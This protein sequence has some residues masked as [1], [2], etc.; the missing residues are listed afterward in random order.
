MTLSPLA[1]WN[2]FYIIVGSAAG[3]LTGLTFVVIA[4]SAGVNRAN[5]TGVHAFLTP[6]VVHFGAVLAVAAY[7]NVPRQ[8]VL[9]LSIGFGLAGAAGLIYCAVIARRFGRFSAQY[10]PAREDWLWNL[11]VP[12]V[13]YATLL[14]M[15]ALSWHQLELSLYGVAAASVALLFVGIRNSWDVAVWNSVKKTPESN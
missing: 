8:S 5:T 1:D 7:L 10:V 14:A 15:A 6:T 11:I 12:A 4:L 3:G 9:S 2:N 13:V